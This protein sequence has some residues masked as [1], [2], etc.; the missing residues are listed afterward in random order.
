M[1]NWAT[2]IA[3]FESASSAEHVSLTD[4]PHLATLADKLGFKESNMPLA[5]YIV[6]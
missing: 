3:T 6:D 4:N 2:A 5:L 1:M